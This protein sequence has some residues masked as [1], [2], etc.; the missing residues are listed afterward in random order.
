MG[1]Q[2]LPF[3]P[4]V[5]PKG[6]RRTALRFRSLRSRRS[7]RTVLT[8]LLFATMPAFAQHAPDNGNSS[9]QAKGPLRVCA[10]PNDLPF[11]NRAGQGFENKL[12]QMVGHSLGKPVQFVWEM[13]GNG[14]LRSVYERK[15]DVVMGLPTDD[16]AFGVLTTDPYYRS[17][18]ALVYRA[19]APFQ[20]K[21]LDDPRLRTLQIGVHSMFG[22]KVD[23]PPGT[24]LANRGIYKNVRGYDLLADYYRQPNPSANLIKAV[25]DGEV[26]V[27]IAWGPLAGYFATRE[28][29]KLTVVPLAHT[30]T[31]LPFQYTISMAVRHDNRALRDALNTFLAAHRADIRNLLTKYGVPQL[32]LPPSD[33]SQ[34]QARAASGAAQ[35]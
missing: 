32:A 9:V 33:A 22:D 6:S 10:D 13:Q 25:A 21:S 16:H 17:A 31:R 20:L 24:T 3:V 14:F 1:T 7:A 8:L 19:N 30:H 23:L 35:D 11:S 34:L 28:P 4:S 2:I 15:C 26:D 18:Y 5:G 27:A 12:A 29:V